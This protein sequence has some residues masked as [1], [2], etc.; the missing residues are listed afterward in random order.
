MMPEKVA[1][2]IPFQ[3]LN[4]LMASLF[5]SSDISRSLDMP[6]R[7]VTAMPSTQTM[8]PNPIQWPDVVENLSTSVPSNSGGI[9]VPKTEQ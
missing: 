5:F 4:S 3:K 6:A 2:R 8:M 7:P 1:T 9:S